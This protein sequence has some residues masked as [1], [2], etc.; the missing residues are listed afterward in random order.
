MDPARTYLGGSSTL[1]V[2]GK[3]ISVSVRA[4]V[5]LRSDA[6]SFELKIR[7]VMRKGEKKIRE[8]M[9][10]ENISRNLL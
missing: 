10:K 9:W 3:K 5:S 2:K 1:S 6:E 7:R 4:D 8:R